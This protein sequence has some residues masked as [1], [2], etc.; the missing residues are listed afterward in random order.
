MSAEDKP[1]NG[2]CGKLL[3]FNRL[4]LPGELEALP[5]FETDFRL[6]DIVIDLW[7]FPDGLNS[8]ASCSIFLIIP[9]VSSES[10]F[11]FFVDRHGRQVH[12]TSG[13][14]CPANSH[15]SASGGVFVEGGS[16]SCRLLIAGFRC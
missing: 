5:D 3:R 2:D 13:V 6:T 1:C 10:L 4:I 14:F 12:L 8:K 9:S 7:S 16:A 15:L 11:K